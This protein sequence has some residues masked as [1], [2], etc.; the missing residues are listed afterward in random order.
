MQRLL[1]RCKLDPAFADAKFNIS[2]ARLKRN[3]RV[4]DLLQM[5]NMED[6][7]ASWQKFSNQI[8]KKP[9]G[10]C[11]DGSLIG[12]GGREAIL[13][14]FIHSDCFSNRFLIIIF[15]RKSLRS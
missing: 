9:V 7:F 6:S 4:F 10:L 13:D 15:Q 11:L 3:F 14:R 1:Q 5:L 12:E 2:I 8:N